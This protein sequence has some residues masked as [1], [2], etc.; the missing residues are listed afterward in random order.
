MLLIAKLIVVYL[1]GLLALR[2][3]ALVALRNRLTRYLCLWV[4]TCPLTFL[5][6]VLLFAIL[7]GGIGAK[8]GIHALFWPRGSAA[9]AA[10]GVAVAVLLAQLGFASYLLAPNRERLLDRI[11]KLIPAAVAVA[12]Y[13]VL[14]PLALTST[15]LAP[16]QNRL[17][18]V[19]ESIREGRR[20][21]QGDLA[22]RFRESF[23]VGYGAY[24]GVTM[25]PLL[26][27]SF[28]PAFDRFSEKWAMGVGLL[29]GAVLAGVLGLLLAALAD[30]LRASALSRGLVHLLTPL[31]QFRTGHPAGSAADGAADGAAAEPE[32]ATPTKEDRVLV[33]LYALLVGVLFVG[34]GLFAESDWI[35]PAVAFCALMGLIST[36]YS[37][38]AYRNPALQ[39]PATVVAL[40]LMTF[41]N[42]YAFDLGSNAE[43]KLKFP[44]LERYY[45]NPQK[46]S[47]AAEFL[48]TAHQDIEARLDDIG[49]H[50]LLA[51][52]GHRKEVTELEKNL[53]RYPSSEQASGGRKT[54]LPLDDND[55]L[56]RWKAFHWKGRG[57]PLMAIVT[58]SGGGIRAAYWTAVVLTELERRFGEE[59]IGFS[60]HVRLVTGASGGM[61]GAAYYVATLD[62]PTQGAPPYRGAERLGKI[63]EGVGEDSLSPVAR[64]LLL[65]DI[66]SVLCPWSQRS[67]RGRTLEEAWQEH[68]KNYDGRGGRPGDSRL[69]RPLRDLVE[70]ERAGWRPSLV[71]SPMLVEDGRR[72]LISN[73]DLHK[74]TRNRGY[75]LNYQGGG[76]EMRWM[77]QVDPRDP[78]S[79]RDYYSISAV[80]FHRLFP[81][82]DR[83]QLSTAIRMSATFPFVSPAV[84]LPTSPPRRVVDAGYY[85]DYG[86]NLA[87]EWILEYRDWILE[88]TSGIVLIQIRDEISESARRE[89]GPTTINAQ[90]ASSEIASAL[91]R[92][93]E[94][95][96][97]PLAGVLEAQ[98]SVMSFRND[99]LVEYLSGHFERGVRSDGTRVYAAG[100]APEFF[101]TVVFE[102]PDGV[103]LSWVLDETD[104]RTLKAGMQ[105]DQGGGD[106]R[107]K[108]RRAQKDWVGTKNRA[109]LDKLVQWWMRSEPERAR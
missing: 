21:S 4:A 79:D 39:L 74:L 47:T 51:D 19:V 57:L 38:L 78:L 15:L 93:A 97:T 37:Y 73:L 71:F 91:S 109:R 3:L 6:F 86:V 98:D 11:G 59:K 81:D 16:R 95:V 82:A 77:P 107:P 99:E 34:L 87:A 43:F 106:P 28:G 92:G 66:P 27:L 69:A 40:L 30:R 48:K 49:R 5:Q 1:V 22:R 56:R 61:L 32:A 76:M 70:G 8:Y 25:L 53:K 94:W 50:R 13:L 46:L 62:D 20:N 104:K 65:R 88:N 12:V 84:A 80:E 54:G 90:P 101:T 108:S 23:R 18:R 24:Y 2:F 35:S 102:G 105:E 55:T 103:A 7:Y 100:D 10:V 41:V 89:L 63:I 33:L 68:T 26:A 64:R 52:P 96:T 9:Q 31:G 75:L 17:H 36:I 67:D 14:V 85:D 44:N 60:S 45:E 58:A 72:L 42:G 29:A 83:F